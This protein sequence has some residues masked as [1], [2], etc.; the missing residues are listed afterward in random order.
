MEGRVPSAD[1]FE[2]LVA[3]DLVWCRSCINV[4]FSECVANQRWNLPRVKEECKDSSTVQLEGECRFNINHTM[5]KRQKVVKASRS[6]W[7][8]AKYKNKDQARQVAKQLVLK[9]FCLFLFLKKIPTS[10]R[11]P[12]TPRTTTLEWES[13]AVP[14][15]STVRIGDKS[16]PKKIDTQGLE[17]GPTTNLDLSVQHHRKPI[18]VQNRLEIIPHSSFIEQKHGYPPLDV[19]LVRK[20]IQE[21]TQW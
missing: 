8:Q 5:K 9:C 3:I 7:V 12:T 1:L 17:S 6:W 20:L 15:V 13:I 2:L 16:W 21:T 14:F 4:R 18:I 10:A 19:F 11:L